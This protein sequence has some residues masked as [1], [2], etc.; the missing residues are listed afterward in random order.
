MLGDGWVVQ[1]NYYLVKGQLRELN[2]VVHLDQ[3]TNLFPRLNSLSRYLIA[4]L[5]PASYFF[6]SSKAA[7]TKNN[8][9]YSVTQEHHSLTE[10]QYPEISSFVDLGMTLITQ[11]W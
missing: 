6:N 11:S 5:A 10:F 7:I 3:E 2:S 1:S 8:T 9:Q 4:S